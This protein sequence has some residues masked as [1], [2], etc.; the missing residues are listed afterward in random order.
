M[1]QPDILENKAKSMMILAMLIFGTIGIFVRYIPLPSSVIA[2]GRGIIGT[3][4]LFLF[5]KGKS[6]PISWPDIR[7][8]LLLLCLSGAALC[9][10]WTFL[11]EA[12]RYTSIA[13]ATLCYYMAPIIVILVSPIFLKEKLTARKLLCVLTALAGMV[14]VS[15]IGQEGGSANMTGVFFGLCAACCY[16]SIVIF[17][18]K[19][20]PMAAYDKTIVQLGLGALL[21]MPYVLLTEN[22]AALDASPFS[23][24]M[25]LV[26]GIVHTGFAYVF[27]FGSMQSLKAQ[28]IALFS[29]LDPIFAI[30]L[31]AVI[32][33]EPLGMT[34]IIGAV[35]VLGSTLVS[36]LKA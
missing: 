36:E 30:L 21:L 22:V 26:V 32:L 23:L 18:K 9:G 4:F 12:Y 8:N 2:V 17:N 28:T 6:I 20:K 7:Q 31:S 16:A 35:L 29:Y 10:N 24:A 13:T 19:I 11:F 15:G 1:N 33:G 14:L 5:I 27:Y 3:A 34:S 25:F